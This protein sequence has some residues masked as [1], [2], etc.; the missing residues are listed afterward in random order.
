MS[1]FIDTDEQQSLILTKLLQSQEES[2]RMIQNEILEVHIYMHNMARKVTYI[3]VH[4]AK[5]FV[6]FHIR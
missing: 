3:Y 5:E 6:N 1:D 2:M 4:V